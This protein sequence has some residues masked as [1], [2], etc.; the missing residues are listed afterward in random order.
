[1]KRRSLPPGVRRLVGIDIPRAS[2]IAHDLEDELRFHIEER[3]AQ[4]ARAG[5]SPDEAL[6]RAREQYGSLEKAAQDISRY[7]HRRHHRMTLRH[8]I[9]T[10]GQDL[11]FALRTLARQPGWTT[12]AVV[13][14]ALGIGANAAVFSVVNTLLI[15]PLRYPHRDRI[16]LITR[17]NA[18][19][20]LTISPSVENL[21]LWVGA[22][23]SGIRMEDAVAW[24]REILRRYGE[25][26]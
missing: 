26:E 3:A 23:P 14:L 13:A 8:F 2:T 11:R 20:G 1:M 25:L 21:E 19:M 9:D 22:Q 7:A 16:V 15:D 10:V 24:A 17:T 18:K 6:R 5:H 4:L 12:I